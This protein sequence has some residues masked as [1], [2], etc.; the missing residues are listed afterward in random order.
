MPIFL[1]PFRTTKKKKRG[2]VG[3][4]LPLYF[5]GQVSSES[6]KANWPQIAGWVGLVESLFKAHFQKKGMVFE[7]G[8]SVL[9]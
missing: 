9:V 5:V 6:Y 7:V 2:G 1:F 8:V 4:H 3:A